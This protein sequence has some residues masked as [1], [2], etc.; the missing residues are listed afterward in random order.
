MS[1]KTAE[2]A[3]DEAKAAKETVTKCYIGPSA[4]GI[5]SGTI[6]NAGLPPALERAIEEY[7][8]IKNLVVP[9]SGLPAANTALK[10]PKSAIS[11]FYRFA[12]EYFGKKEGR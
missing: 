6:Y 11:R 3:A 12:E 7:P 4:L 1:T 8:I 9:L 10:D 2:A 5:N